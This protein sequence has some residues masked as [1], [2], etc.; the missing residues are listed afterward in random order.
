MRIT[1][2]YFIQ[3]ALVLLILSI[4]SLLV[5]L[6]AFKSVV[7]DNQDQELYIESS[8]S[9]SSL[10]M[11]LDSIVRDTNSINRLAKLLQFKQ[12]K[13][14]HYIIKAG[15]NN[16]SIINKLRK[17]VQEPVTL[18]LNSIRDCYQLAGKL[19]NSLMTD[20]I[21]F[22]LMLQDSNLL[23][24]YS[25]TN[26]NILTA[27]IA[28]S[29]Q[30]Y[31]TITPERLLQRMIQENETFWNKENRTQK[32]AERELT[33]TDVYIIA[34][35]V[36]KETIVEKEKSDIAGVYINRLKSGMKLQADPTVVFAL[37]LFGIQRVLLEHLKA[38]SPYNTYLV[39]GL[40]PGPICMPS[41][42]TLDAVIHATQHEYLFFCARPGYDGSHAFAKTLAGHYENAKVY[43]K[44]L[45]SQKIR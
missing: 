22:L 3:T 37:G 41:I 23:K 12:L 16:L 33:K 10:G 15:S 11:L 29:Y 43:R 14:G 40:P 45:N 17:G 28:N 1:K 21:D 36:E 25:Y 9:I 18:V 35:I 34:S 7:K 13:P 6:N 2:V 8:V 5:Y 38:D 30:V 26:E 39:D 4:A 19:G 44:W 31:W 42:T 20:S 32:I 27:F 24:K